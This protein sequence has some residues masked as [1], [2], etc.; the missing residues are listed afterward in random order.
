VDIRAVEHLSPSRS[1]AQVLIPEPTTLI[2]QKVIAYQRRR[3]KP[4]Q[5]RIGAIWQ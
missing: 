5:E 1:V 2:A 3:G 4:K